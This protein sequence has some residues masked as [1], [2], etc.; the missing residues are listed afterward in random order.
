MKAAATSDIFQ[1]IMNLVGIPW[2]PALFYGRGRSS[3]FHLHRNYLG[4]TAAFMARESP[5][6][7]TQQI[8][9]YI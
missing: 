5:L 4:R 1:I 7:E 3:S 6:A 2:L 8:I 9:L